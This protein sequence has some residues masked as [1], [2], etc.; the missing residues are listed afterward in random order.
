VANHEH[1]RYFLDTE[2]KEHY[3]LIAHL[4]TSFH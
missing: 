1:L 2:F 3:R 4:S